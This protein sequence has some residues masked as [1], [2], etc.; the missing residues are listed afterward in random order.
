MH[1]KNSSIFLIAL[2]AAVTT[3]AIVGWLL[4]WKCYARSKALENDVT[5]LR[6]DLND[7]TAKIVDQEEQLNAL[8]QA[9]ASQNTVYITSVSKTFHSNNGCKLILSLYEP[10]PVDRAYAIMHG[11]TP[12][13]SCCK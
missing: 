6:A 13:L 4:T 9:T 11:Y 2:L 5:S 7:A 12:C 1:N 10:T 8:L 3:V